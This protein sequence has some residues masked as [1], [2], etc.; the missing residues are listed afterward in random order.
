M[1]KSSDSKN[2]RPNKSHDDAPGKGF[3]I[4]MD[5]QSVADGPPWRTYNIR[6]KIIPSKAHQDLKV[7]S[8][9]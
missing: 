3:D 2:L 9:E 6:H 4:F 8:R 1:S 5:G 7:E